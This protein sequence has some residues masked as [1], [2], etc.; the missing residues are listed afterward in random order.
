MNEDLNLLVLDTEVYSNT[1]GQASKATPKGAVAQFAAAGRKSAKKD[2]GLMAMTYQNVYVAQVA[3]GANPGQY[4]KALREAESYPGTSLII[5]Y[6]TCLNHGLKCGME[7]SMGEMKRAVD[8]GY[9]NL[10]RYDPRRREQGLNPFQLDSGEPKG[11]FR[12][13]L[14]G[15]IRFASLF[16]SFP[17]EAERLMA[18]AETEAIKRYQQYKT[19]AGDN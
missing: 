7:D 10:Y 9:W 1:G 13:F 8:S 16:A 15:E 5:A 2:L 11:D 3:I 12:A 6:A 14:N 17:D 19:M 18:E 4:L